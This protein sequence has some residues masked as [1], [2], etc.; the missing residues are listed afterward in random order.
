MLFS[1]FRPKFGKCKGVSP[2]CFRIFGQNLEN[3]KGVSPCC[4]RIFGQNLEKC[5]GVRPNE[6]PWKLNRFHKFSSIL[7]YLYFFLSLWNSWDLNFIFCFHQLQLGIIYEQLAQLVRYWSLDAWVVKGVY[8][9]DPQ[10]IDKL[11][12]IPI[13]KTFQVAM[14]HIPQF[15]VDYT[16]VGVFSESMGAF[17]YLF[18]CSFINSWIFGVG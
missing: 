4:F 17:H 6:N 2:C 10:E 15:N 13:A 8:V 18:I 16:P 11:N 3:C 12:W 1:N 9:R 5:K 14:K 7:L